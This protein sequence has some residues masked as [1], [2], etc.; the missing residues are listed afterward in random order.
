M[1]VRIQTR[2]LKKA[3]NR[4]AISSFLPVRPS[5]QAHQR[6]KRETH[7]HAHAERTL[8]PAWIHSAFLSFHAFQQGKGKTSL[9]SPLTSIHP[10]IHPL[11]IESLRP[12]SHSC[13]ERLHL[14]R[15]LLLLPDTE[16]QHDLLTSTGNGPR[17]N[18]PVQ[19]LDLPSLSPSRVREPTEDLSGLAS[20][21]LKQLR[22]LDLAQSC[23]A[24]EFE[25]PFLAVHLVQL[26]ADVLDLGP[27]SLNLSCH[28]SQLVP[29]H[30][31]FDQFLPEGLSLVGVL[32]R[33][34]VEHTGETGSRHAQTETLVVE[35][36][37]D[38]LESLVLLSNQILHRDLHIIE[39]DERSA[40]APHAHA[41][42]L[43]RAH[44]C[45]LSGHQQKRETPEAGFSSPA[46]DGEVVCKHSVGDPLLLP[47]EDVVLPV[48]GLRGSCG[49]IRN[50]AAGC[51]L[52][53]AQADELV[54]VQTGLHHPVLQGLGAPVEDGRESDRETAK[55]PPRQPSTA[56]SANLVN[57][58]TPVE[59]VEFF[60]LDSSGNL[61]ACILHR[62]P[63]GANGGLQDPCCS[64]AFEEGLGEL[65]RLVPR[66]DLPCHLGLDPLSNCAPHRLVGVVVVP[67]VVPALVPVGVPVRRQLSKQTQVVVVDDVQ[68]SLCRL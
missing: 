55:Q 59:S 39:G 42:H 25:E 61:R 47:V 13:Q 21:E 43:P 34:L 45:E 33:F 30:L 22:S 41:V 50:V 63:V 32:K 16:F 6:R 18:F 7:T 9:F 64:R 12:H 29:N 14:L 65:L 20:A 2:T 4:T 1:H 53:D 49:Q 11:I 51:R 36:V 40:A 58:D 68:L 56:S 3:K 37:H 35:V 23:G 5:T 60:G 27:V 10:Y 54:S 19:T 62:G 26:E 31:M 52:C 46:C 8:G 48:G 44:A 38:V 66:V 24:T 67:R 15:H 17:P 57:D 28:L